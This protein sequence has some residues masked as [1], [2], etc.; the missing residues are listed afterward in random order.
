MC[1][2]LTWNVLRVLTN[3]FVHPPFERLIELLSHS[4]RLSETRIVFEV[5]KK[6]CVNVNTLSLIQ[7][8]CLFC[9]LFRFFVSTDKYESLFFFPDWDNICYKIFGIIYLLEPSLHL[10]RIFWSCVTPPLLFLSYIM[11]TIASTLKKYWLQ[12]TTFKKHRAS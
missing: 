4:Q 5:W 12:K 6:H 3:L 7:W 11:K 8:F 9:F 10:K 2:S 1:K